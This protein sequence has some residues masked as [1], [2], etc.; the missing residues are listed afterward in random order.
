MLGKRTF[1]QNKKS[2]IIYTDRSTKILDKQSLSRN[3]MHI[4]ENL[5]CLKKFPYFKCM[6]KCFFQL[7][8]ESLNSMN[9]V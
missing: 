6:L 9:F 2:E 1:V 7:K 8:L 4:F 5:R 3:C